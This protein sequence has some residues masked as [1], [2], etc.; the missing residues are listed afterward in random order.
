MRKPAYL[1]AKMGSIYPTNPHDLFRSCHFQAPVGPPCRGTGLSCMRTL[2]GGRREHH[3]TSCNHQ[4]FSLSV[5][6]SN[7][8]EPASTQL[9]RCSISHARQPGPAA[10]K[11]LWLANCGFQS[12]HTCRFALLI[13]PIDD[14]FAQNSRRRDFD[15]RK[16]RPVSRYG[17]PGRLS[18][19][20]EKNS[21]VSRRLRHTSSALGTTKPSRY[22]R[23]SIAVASGE[24]G[25]TSFFGSNFRTGPIEIG[26]FFRSTPLSS[27]C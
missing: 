14:T 18:K 23:V 5:E 6:G 7:G 9:Q 26:Y 25:K 8:V 20:T 17:L 4:E 11:P 2:C 24:S 21:N 10:Q 13:T 22:S 15:N 27:R 16:R 3:R 12:A 19:L 1:S